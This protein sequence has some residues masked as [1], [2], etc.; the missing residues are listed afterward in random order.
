MAPRDFFNE[1]ERDLN[2]LFKMT[3]STFNRP[4]KDMQPYKWYKKDNGLVFVINTLG[5][6]KKDV[7]VQINTERG[8]PY[9]YLHVK[10]QTKMEKIDFENTVELAI[11]LIMDDEIEDVSYDVRDGLTIV[12]LKLKKESKEPLLKAKAIESEEFDF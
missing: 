11:R 8:D 1:F 12:Y 9:R 10:G 3:F 2:N 6:S 5:I 4:V 7:S